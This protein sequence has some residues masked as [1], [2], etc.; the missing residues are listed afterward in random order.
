VC[1]MGIASA[2]SP[3]QDDRL[4][5]LLTCLERA[6]KARDERRRI[7]MQRNGRLSA[8]LHDVPSAGAPNILGNP[9]SDGQL[10]PATLRPGMASDAD[11]ERMLLEGL[12][13][14]CFPRAAQLSPIP[15]LAPIDSQRAVPRRVSID[16]DKLMLTATFRRPRRAFSGGPFLIGGVIAAVWAGYFVFASRPAPIDFTEAPSSAS[17]ETRLLL[18]SAL[19]QADLL[20]TRL[21]GL[22]AGGEAGPE[23]Q[24]TMLSESQVSENGTEAR[25]PQ[26]PS[27]TKYKETTGESNAMPGSGSVEQASPKSG[28]DAALGGQNTKPLIEKGR[29]VSPESVQVSTCFPSASAVRQEYPEAWP[30]WTLRAAGHEGTKCWYAATRRRPVT[31]YKEATGEGN[32]MPGSGSV[33]QALLKSGVDAA[34]GGQNTKPLIEKGRLVSPESVQVSTCFPSASAVRLQYPEAWPSWTLR[35]A[36][37]EGTKCWYAATRRPPTI[38]EVR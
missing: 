14:G 36:G 37:H 1:D 31:E 5:N 7:G 21:E 35:A 38:I 26:T 4:N 2:N 25:L 24:L 22:T 10:Q 34:L 23:P 16:L 11:F 28:V 19:P 15:R 33:E 20:S 17:N 3:G 6:E 9:K 32:A 12:P 8:P 18:L 27:A 29:L 30:S 13:I